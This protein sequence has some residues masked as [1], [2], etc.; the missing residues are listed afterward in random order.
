MDSGC[1][2]KNDPGF[3]KPIVECTMT[4]QILWATMYTSVSTLPVPRRGAGGRGAGSRYGV[5]AMSVRASQRSPG[6][7]EER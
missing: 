2:F 3:R 1:I 7:A 5:N 6:P 4:S